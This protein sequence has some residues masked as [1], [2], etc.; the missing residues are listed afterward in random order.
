MNSGR[1]CTFLLQFVSTIEPDYSKVELVIY[2]A[3][4]LVYSWMP[5]G[6]VTCERP[7]SFTSRGGQHSV[8]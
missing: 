8:G 4:P 7:V 3:L 1:N 5:A 2:I 6:C